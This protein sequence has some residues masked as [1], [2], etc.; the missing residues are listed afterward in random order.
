MARTE[1]LEY[2]ASAAP[3]LFV[4]S[5]EVHAILSTA[6]RASSLVLEIADSEPGGPQALSDLG[7]V[8]DTLAR[9]T[10]NL[11]G[12]MNLVGLVIGD[13]QADEAQPRSVAASA[14]RAI[15]AFQGLTDRFEITVKNRVGEEAITLPMTSS[16]LTSILV[17]GLSNAMKAVIAGGEDRRV[18]V[19]GSRSA[20]GLVL[21][22][23][24][25]G[26][27]LPEAHW[28]EVFEPLTSDPGG[29]LYPRLKKA[30]ADEELAGLAR[31]TGLGLTITRSIVSRHGGSVS[32]V[33]PPPNWNTCLEIRLP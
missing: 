2:L 24:D 20:D 29:K 9:L 32:F 7:P 12:V 31:G 6:R 21:A 3:L 28:E 17:N 30:L 11:R 10:N 15:T 25:S 13:K 16:A 22:I 27:G 19:D 33:P 23:L 4:F 26:I 8:G 18:R 5:H 1:M 14:D